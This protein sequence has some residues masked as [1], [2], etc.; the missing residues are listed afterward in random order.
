M[1]RSLEKE[2]MDLADKPHD[3]YLDD[4]RN[5]RRFNRYL[6]GC[7]S[8][9]KGLASVAKAQPMSRLSIL[10]IGSSSADIPKAMAKWARRRSIRAEI[11]AL[12]P[13]A[14]AAEVARSQA[15]DYREIAVIRGDGANVP[16]RARVRCGHGL[17]VTTP[18]FRSGNHRPAEEL[19]S[20]GALGDHCQRPGAP[21][22]RLSRHS[23]H[24]HTVHP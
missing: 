14:M 12:E 21:S 6:G 15:R 11:V 17:A 24:H 22:A 16:F 3:L 7:R 23:L 18:F 2:M 10:D 9:L 20:T 19:V 8:V 5:L 13:D 4:L 1:K